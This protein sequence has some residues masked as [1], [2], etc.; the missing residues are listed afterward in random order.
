MRIAKIFKCVLLNE[1]LVHYGQGKG[2]FGVSGL[3]ANLKEMQ[4]GELRNLR[5][6]YNN[7]YISLSKFMIAIVYSVLKYIRR[8]FIVKFRLIC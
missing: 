5:Y 1:Q 6:A 8:I 3:S 2:G 4:K 7:N